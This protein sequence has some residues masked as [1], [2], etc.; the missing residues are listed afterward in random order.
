M[1]SIG[2]AGDDL[3]NGPT[4]H[5]TPGGIAFPPPWLGTEM[6][7][8]SARPGLNHQAGVAAIVE[9]T[10]EAAGLNPVGRLDPIRSVRPRLLRWR[11]RSS[12]G[13]GEQKKAAPQGRCYSKIHVK[14]AW[15]TP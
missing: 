14:K 2:T 12:R 4:G 9:A 13:M 15:K 7:A 1:A 8:S 6:T 3:G 5:R 10:V 11:S